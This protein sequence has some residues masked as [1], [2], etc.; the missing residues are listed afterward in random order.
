MTAED[1][2][3]IRMAIGEHLEELRQRLLYALG[4][5]IVGMAMSLIFRGAILTVLEY[6]YRQVMTELGKDPSLWVFKASAGFLI[7]MKVSLIGGLLLSSPWI[8]YQFWAFA[9]AGLYRRERRYVLIAVPFSAG[10]FVTGAM[11]FLLVAALPLLRFFVGFN[12]SLGIETRLTL[13]NHV[14]MMTGMM[15][16]FGLGFQLPVVVAL[17]GAMGLV[18]ARTLSKYRRHVI[19]ILLIFSALVTSPSPVDQVLLA[20]PMWLLY[21]LGI[22]LVWLMKRKKNRVI[23]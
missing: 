18:T 1:P 20:V 17:L 21:E 6:P 11:F 14:S 8:F 4:G 23:F 12:Q 3:E 10:L 19:V 9:S 2:G 15:I 16:A 13:H 7:Y 5:L 22:I